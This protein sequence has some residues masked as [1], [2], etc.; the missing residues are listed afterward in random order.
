MKDT[1]PGI[2]LSLILLPPLSL[3]VGLRTVSFTSVLNQPLPPPPSPSNSIS[4]SQLP[5]PPQPPPPRATLNR[6]PSSPSA[7]ARSTV[8]PRVEPPSLSKQPSLPLKATSV[9]SCRKPRS[10][11]VGSSGNDEE[12]DGDYVNDDLDKNSPPSYP[13][14]SPLHSLPASLASR[15]TPNKGAGQKA[16]P[17]AG[18]GDA[19]EMGKMRDTVKFLEKLVNAVQE[20]S[21]KELSSMQRQITELKSQVETLSNKCK[22]LEQQLERSGGQI[23]PAGEQAPHTY[24][25]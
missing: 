25:H 17:T 16:G 15:N 14:P 2:T 10:R 22:N 12:D 6:N 24:T 1:S 3:S 18:G 8:R 20:N 13:P 9:E 7:Q 21:H 11:T 5:P 23:S 19:T 4:S